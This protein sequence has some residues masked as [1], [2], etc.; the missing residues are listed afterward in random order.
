MSL[1][2]RPEDYVSA[3]VALRPS[4][5]SSKFLKEMNGYYQVNIKITKLYS[6]NCKSLAL[7]LTGSAYLLIS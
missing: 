5:E 6:K 7:I 3:E 1:S 4:Q 2:G